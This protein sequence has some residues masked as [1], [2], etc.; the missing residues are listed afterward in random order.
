MQD[1]EPSWKADPSSHNVVLQPALL[2][3]EP[4]L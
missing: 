1:Q 3:A 2:A 4:T